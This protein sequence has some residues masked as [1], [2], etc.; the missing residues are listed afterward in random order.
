MPEGS[1][2]LR[3]RV[4]VGDAEVD[5]RARESEKLSAREVVESMERRV[6][7]RCAVPP[8]HLLEDEPDLRRAPG[9]VRVRVERREARVDSHRD[10]AQ[11]G[12]GGNFRV[13][14]TVG[15]SAVWKRGPA[16]E[17]DARVERARQEGAEVA[18]CGRGE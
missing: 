8:V 13:H 9:A 16:D 5:E 17:P 10:D 11:A 12:V 14:G 4:L 3:V 2:G 18:A 6:E 7:R 1:G 15:R